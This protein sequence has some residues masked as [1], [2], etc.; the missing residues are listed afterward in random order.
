MSKKKP[1]GQ[2]LLFIFVMTLIVALTIS[3]IPSKKDKEKEPSLLEMVP[4]V[5]QSR[6]LESGEDLT[7]K[8]EPGK[9]SGAQEVKEK[10][11][12]QVPSTEPEVQAA[13]EGDIAVA[14]DDGQEV[15][16]KVEPVLPPAEKED[17]IPAAPA[18]EEKK[19][20]VAVK[21]EKAL[22]EPEK[23]AVAVKSEKALPEP[24]KP[25][26]ES[27]KP[28]AGSEKALE[29]GAIAQKETPKEPEAAQ[30]VVAPA[31]DKAREDAVAPGDTAV[32]A[33][34]ADPAPGQEE[35]TQAEVPPQASG[36]T[37]VE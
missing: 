24:E 14:H 18:V 30:P 8:A 23:P 35:P 20:A 16:A 15:A 28:A 5:T 19:P 3:I 29:T 31:D 36:S 12:A 13:P 34:P 2:N 33:A 4:S 10:A 17:K 21:A 1:E 26:A 32:A 37:T 22:P 11:T 25:A 27:E 6:Q 7:A 9:V